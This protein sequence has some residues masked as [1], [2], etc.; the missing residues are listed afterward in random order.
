MFTLSRTD[1]LDL[2]TTAATVGRNDNAIRDAKTRST[3]KPLSSVGCSLSSPRP[4]AHR[5]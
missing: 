4:A 3:S 1:L 5:P 2:L